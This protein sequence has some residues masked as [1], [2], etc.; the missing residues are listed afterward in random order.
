MLLMVHPTF[1][2]WT[3]D[4]KSI[5]YGGKLKSVLC[6]N[7]SNQIIKQVERGTA[8]ST[9]ICEGSRKMAPSGRNWPTLCM[10]GANGIRF[11]WKKNWSHVASGLQFLYFGLYLGPHKTST[12]GQ[13]EPRLCMEGAN[14]IRCP[15]KKIE[16]IQPLTSDFHIQVSIK[17]PFVMI[18]SRLLMLGPS[19][20][21]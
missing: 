3:F 13:K 12:S 9:F 6:L 16:A 4:L 7:N 20:S 8:K 15:E 11:P 19:N 17:I 1:Q 10:E 2:S 14:G 18:S 21:A 5:K